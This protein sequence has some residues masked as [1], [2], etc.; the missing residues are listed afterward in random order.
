MIDF[1]NML[2]FCTDSASIWQL[3]GRVVNIVKIVI[4]I[5]IVLFAMLDLGK[6]VIAGKEDDIKNAQKMLIK[7]LIYGVIIF[8]VVTI[9]QTVFNLIGQNIYD[10]DSPDADADVCM[11]CVSNPSSPD[12]PANNNSG[13]NAGTNSGTNSGNGGSG[14]SQNNRV[15]FEQ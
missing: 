8:F 11:I 3:L 7:R 4:P 2:G 6:A 15:D 12:C 14:G 9:V 10:P 13:T 1:I 5:I